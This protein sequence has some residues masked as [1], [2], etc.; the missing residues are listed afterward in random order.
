MPKAFPLTRL[1]LL[2]GPA[3]CCDAWCCS[4]G[5]DAAHCLVVDTQLLPA[6]CAVLHAANALNHILVGVLL[7]PLGY[8]TA[9]GCSPRGERCH[10]ARCRATSCTLGRDLPIASIRRYDGD[11]YLFRRATMLS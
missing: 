7:I 4:S 6:Y 5:S 8:L 2:R 9:Y 10:L 3:Y 11:A 1:R